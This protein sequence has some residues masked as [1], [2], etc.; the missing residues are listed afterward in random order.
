MLPMVLVSYRNLVALELPRKFSKFCAWLG[1]GTKLD[2][3]QINR[4][5]CEHHAEVFEV[6][7]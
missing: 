7:H 5:V 3:L 1:I 2:L 4:I 6:F